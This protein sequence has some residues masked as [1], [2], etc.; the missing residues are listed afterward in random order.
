MWELCM[1]LDYD[2]FMH[3]MQIPATNQYFSWDQQPVCEPRFLKKE[4]N[5]SGS[6]FHYNRL[7]N[8]KKLTLPLK[9]YFKTL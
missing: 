5:F 7:A 9:K 1:H 6:K 2:H 3:K 4:T 8:R